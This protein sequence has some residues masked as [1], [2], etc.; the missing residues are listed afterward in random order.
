M[1]GGPFRFTEL[2]NTAL[3][4][5]VHPSN[6]VSLLSPA[7]SREARGAAEEPENSRLCIGGNCYCEVGALVKLG[8]QIVSH[9]SVAQNVVLVGRI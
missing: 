7:V 9:E 4:P 2:K 8:L 3:P 1:P 6:T 5:V